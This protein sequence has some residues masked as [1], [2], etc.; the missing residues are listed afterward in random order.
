MRST[1]VMS[2]RRQ[3]YRWSP[4]AS[5]ASLR[6]PQALTSAAKVQ[7]CNMEGIGRCL[8]GYIAAARTAKLSLG[9][10]CALACVSRRTM[11][12]SDPRRYDTRS[13]RRCSSTGHG[14]PRGLTLPSTRLGAGPSTCP[15]CCRSPV[16]PAGHACEAIEEVTSRHRGEDGREPC[17]DPQHAPCRR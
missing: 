16:R 9:Q 8:Q 15:T 6:P 13:L 1:C 3:Q 4:S 17:T 5:S 7:I 10:H 11:P 12:A 2:I 14:A